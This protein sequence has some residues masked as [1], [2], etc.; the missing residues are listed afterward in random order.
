MNSWMKKKML[1]HHLENWLETLG[2]LLES[3]YLLNINLLL[4]FYSLNNCKAP[5]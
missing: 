4:T 2:K 1:V 5:A 3:K